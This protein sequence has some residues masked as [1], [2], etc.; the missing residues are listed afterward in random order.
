[1]INLKILDDIPK[2]PGV[3]LIKGA[4][5][6]V[7]YIGKAVNLHNRVKSY[8][9]RSG[10]VRQSIPFILRKVKD[11]EWVVTNTEK[12]ALLL[13]NILIKR[14]QPR[15][16]VRLVDDKTYVSLKLDIKSKF[17][18]LR[19]VRIR[20]KQKDGALY[21]GP[22]SS[23]NSVRETVR[24]IHRI[25][26]IRTCNDT[27]F[28]SHRTRP[29]LD[30]QIKKCSGPCADFI[31][32]EDYK[33]II[34]NVILFL[35]GRNTEL[36]EILRGKMREE[37]DR[38]NFEEAQRIL[39]QIQAIEATIEKQRVFSTR[40]ANQDVFG[41]YREGEE[42]Q[43]SIMH[44]R[45]GQLVETTTKSFSDMQISNEEILSSLISQFYREEGYIP[46]EILIPLKLTDMGL[47]SE[48]L[49]E[50]RGGKV[51]VVAPQRGDK[52]KLVEM[53]Q[54]NAKSFFVASKDEEKIRRA[55]L[56]QMKQKFR[57]QTFP[58]R[59]DCFDISNIRGTLAVGSMV[60]FI[61][62]KADKSNYRK[63][64]IKTISQA[65]DYG[66]MEEVLSRRYLKAKEQNELPN[67]I[68]IDGGKGQL[69]IA[70]KILQ[71]LNLKNI[72]VISIAK[73]KSHWEAGKLRIEKIYLPNVKDPIRLKMNSPILFLLQRIRNEA[74]R[75]AITYHKTLR[76]KA[77]LHSVL[78]EIKGVGAKRKKLLLRHFGSLKKISEAS[79]QQLLAVPNMPRSLAE[80]VYEQLHTPDNIS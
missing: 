72:D 38:L 48:I 52:R 20:E 53:A 22:Y 57:L 19:I 37:A 67:L 54:K 62:G 8:F 10:D 78:D 39:N 16:N 60:V 27:K 63:F 66:M 3:Y 70:V 31:S 4:R 32:E 35:E 7:I 71:S 64:K 77:K 28:R 29:C 55:T 61:S 14:H 76:K 5:G 21:F 41:L 59:I 1:M 11:I 45:D 25:F 69:N 49:T 56:E 34:R 68:I 51:M 58:K 6:T 23:A 74:H 47:L 46:P 18:R 24:M 42:V 40:W 30:Y 9:A 36:L 79:L 44:I 15:Y 26:P 73:D 2:S 17:P 12:E 75:F 80:K 65:D 13:E 33:K 43:L 50:R